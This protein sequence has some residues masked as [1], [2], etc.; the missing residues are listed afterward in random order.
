MAQP[1][2]IGE[3]WLAVRR[4]AAKFDPEAAERDRDEPNAQM[5]RNLERSTVEVWVTALD[6]AADGSYQTTSAR[7]YLAAK[8]IEDTTHRLAKPEEI[9]AERQRRHLIGEEIKRQNAELKGTITTQTML[10]TIGQAMVNAQQSG[11]A[12][13]KPKGAAQAP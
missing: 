12:E 4:L 2:T 8:W 6:K 11:A 7:A 1:R 9:E 3:Y 10:E 13:R 5:R